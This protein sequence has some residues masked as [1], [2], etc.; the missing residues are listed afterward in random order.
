MNV[1]TVLHL[2]IDAFFAAVEVMINP[3]LKGKPVIV[4]GL[5][6]ERGVVCTASYE[7]R[8]YGV[9]S[10]MALRSAARLCPQGIFLRGR[11]HVYRQISKRFFDCLRGFSPLVEE[12]SVDEGYVGLK[13]SRYQSPSVYELAQRIK[14]AT[15]AETGL[16]IT[17]GMGMSRLGAKLATELAKPGGLCWIQDE[18]SFLSS[19]SIE[20][21]PG[22]G[23]RTVLI[24]QGLG[25]RWVEDLKSRYPSQWKKLVGC[26]LYYTSCMDQRRE[27]K[28]RSYSR[29]TTFPSDIT[30][31]EMILSHMAYLVDRLSMHLVKQACFAGRIEVKIRFSDF[32][33]FSKRAALPFPTYSYTHLRYAAF[34]LLERLIK[35]KGL[36]LRLIGVKVE[37]IA[38][39]RDILPF[40]S[41]K[42]ERLTTSIQDIKARFGFFSIVTG[43]EMLLET[44]YPIEREGVV[45]R[46]AS[47]T[48]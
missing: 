25:V 23:P 13:G 5:A 12:V 14:Q 1:P 39:Q 31:R 19:L 46:T 45:L 29:E 11:Y 15:E 8:K 16:Q 34:T 32:S 26:H 37:K 24:L 43:R 38:E 4:G 47:L 10:G 18:E 3:S 40:F 28:V 9:H 2:D 7:A 22:I 42:N 20:K 41:L 27:P 36:P 17:G 21:I 35:K 30:D 48:K 44:L 6:H 33:T